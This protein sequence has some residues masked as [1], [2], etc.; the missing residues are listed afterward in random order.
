MVQLGGG[1]Q[2]L[3]S[4]E[5]SSKVSAFSHLTDGTRGRDV[6]PPRTQH[7]LGM[8]LCTGALLRTSSHF[9]FLASLQR[10][11]PTPTLQ[12]TGQLGRDLG[13]DNGEEQEFSSA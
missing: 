5:L 7:S 3:Q 13:A 8:G 2:G 9:T 12:M 10:K 4:A 6:S 1:A 11:H